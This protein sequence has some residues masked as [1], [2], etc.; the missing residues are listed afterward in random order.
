M[1]LG[2]FDTDGHKLT[3]NTLTMTM[4]MAAAPAMGAGTHR[5]DSFL[6]LFPSSSG[7][8]GRWKWNLLRSSGI[9]SGGNIEY[10]RI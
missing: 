6:S 2:T 1:K 4:T 8:L 10:T 7:R 9:G 5:V 3:G